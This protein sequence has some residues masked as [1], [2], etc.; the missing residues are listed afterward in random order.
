LRRNQIAQMGDK[1]LDKV[2]LGG[3]DT[4]EEDEDEPST[5]NYGRFVP[6]EE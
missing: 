1:I 4:I 6:I 5:S 2:F 3:S